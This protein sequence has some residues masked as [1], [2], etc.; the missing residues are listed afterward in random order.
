[1]FT[2]TGH[3]PGQPPCYRLND[4]DGEPIQGTF[5]EAELQKV[6]VGKDKAF[7]EEI[8]EEQVVRGKKE[9]LVC[10]KNSSKKFNRWVKASDLKKLMNKT[11]IH[12]IQREV[13][14][15]LTLQC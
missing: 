14:R 6:K 8:L 2:V 3:K 7:V 13:L 15:N 11:Q 1:M 12:W 4:Y 10:W 5:Y 9:M